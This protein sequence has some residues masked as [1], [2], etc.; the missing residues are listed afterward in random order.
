M[1]HSRGGR[2]AAAPILRLRDLAIVSRDLVDE[3]DDDELEEAGREFPDSSSVE[4]ATRVVVLEIRHSSALFSSPSSAIVSRDSNRPPFR[5]SPIAIT[6]H[7]GRSDEA[8][9]ETSFSIIE[10]SQTLEGIKAGGIALACETNRSHVCCAA[11]KVR[12]I[13]LTDGMRRSF[14]HP[15]S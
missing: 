5:R 6:C 8:Q 14:S 9:L 2:G 13:S 1:A 12:L 7:A 3:P 15:T 4:S 10:G 11:K